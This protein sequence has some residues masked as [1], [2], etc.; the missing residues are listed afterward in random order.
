MSQPPLF[1]RGFVAVLLTQSVFGYSF[2]CFYLL[3]KFLATELGAG[4]L[5]IGQVT[6]LYGVAAVVFMPLAGRWVDRF[7]RLQFLRAGIALLGVS[8]AGFLWVESLGPLI[9]ALRFLHGVAWALAFSGAGAV[10]T[11]HAPP[12]RMGQAIGLFGVSML[13]MNAVAPGVAEWLALREGWDAVFVMSALAAGVSLL[14]S[15]TLRETHRPSADDEVPGLVAVLA[16]PRALWFL[17]IIACFGASFG[18]MFT[19]SQPF[20]LELGIEQVSVFF[21]AYTGAAIVVRLALGPLADRSGRERVS[22]ASGVW[23]ALSVLAMAALEPGRLAWIG[24]AFG[25]AHGLFYPALNAL[26]LEG[27]SAH[28]RGKVM[29]LFNGAFNLGWAVSGIA[30]GLLAERAGYPIVFVVAS[31]VTFAGVGLLA[32]GRPRRP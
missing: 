17:S 21:V 24:A 1:T 4:A 6:T 2:A 15:A 5:E 19:F 31:A 20:A 29:A 7:G 12:E 18:A 26:A 16:R 10:V 27:A 30:L 8:A 32:A 13:A 3:P 23:Y 28:E 14:L 22:L 25:L 9:Y 11:D